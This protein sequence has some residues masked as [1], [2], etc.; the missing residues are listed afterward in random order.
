MNYSTPG[1]SV[2]CYHTG[3]AQTHVHWVSD[4][5]QPSYPLSS[6]SLALNLSPGS[7]SFPVIQLF[8]SG[9][10]SIAVSAS[11]SALSMTIQGWSPLGLTGLIYLLSK[12]LSRVFSIT[13]IQKHQFFTSQLSFFIHDYR[14]NHSF[15]YMDLCQQS[16]V[17][18]FLICCL[19]SSELFF[20]GT[21]V[22]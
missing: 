16:D 3:F 19:G 10:Q 14:K 8:P 22:F 7:G 5:I 12:S 18:I 9:G 1:F 17:S 6:P 15:D 20:K 11:A 21:R 4:A 13:K 2:L